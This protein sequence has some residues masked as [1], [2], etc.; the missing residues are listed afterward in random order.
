M[1]KKILFIILLSPLIPSC[2]KD[3]FED[4]TRECIENIVI[5]NKKYSENAS[6]YFK[7][8]IRNDSLS[9]YHGDGDYIFELRQFS[10]G[11]SLPGEW[12]DP[13]DTSKLTEI[14][15]VFF[16]HNSDYSV[17][18]EVVSPSYSKNTPI[19]KMIDDIGKYEHLKIGDNNNKINNGYTFKWLNKC[20]SN[21]EDYIVICTGSAWNDIYFYDQFL[22]WIKVKKFE[23]KKVFNNCV[24]DII[25][26]IN[27]NLFSKMGYYG[28]LK[29]TYKTYFSI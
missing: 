10:R 13:S 17:V 18:F 27:V 21:A 28:E 11:F 25:F 4:K 22:K 14:G 2:S 24:Y 7:G 20:Q 16:F 6:I 29:G 1:M 26:D 12:F 8:K 23:K 5:P 19:E 9:I 15:I 3:F